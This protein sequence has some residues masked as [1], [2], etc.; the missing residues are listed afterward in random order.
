MASFRRYRPWAGRANVV[1]GPDGLFQMQGQIV[2]IENQSVKDVVAEVR[3]SVVPLIWSWVAV[4]RQTT[5]S[6]QLAGFSLRTTLAAVIP[7]EELLDYG[8]LLVYTEPVEA[9]LAASRLESLDLGPRASSL[10]LAMHLM[11]STYMG[12]AQSCGCLPRC[13][14]PRLQCG[15]ASAN[16][17]SKNYVLRHQRTMW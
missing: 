13:A 10:G 5:D 7:D 14:V 15:R 8:R 3:R 9:G 1:S 12:Q 4:R 6:W 16:V 11:G 17:D 2:P